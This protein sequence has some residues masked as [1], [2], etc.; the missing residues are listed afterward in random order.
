M[1]QA[2]KPMDGMVL[3]AGLLSYSERGVE[4]VETIRSIIDANNL[5]RLD[6]ARLRDGEAAPLI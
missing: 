6:D 3:A 5:R 1:R 2:G 4:Y